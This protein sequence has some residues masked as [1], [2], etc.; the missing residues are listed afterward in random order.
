MSA[1]TINLE[2]KTQFLMKLLIGT[3]QEIERKIPL[4][5]T[6]GSLAHHN[7]LLQRP[8]KKHFSYV[9]KC[10]TLYLTTFLEPFPYVL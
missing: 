1:L 5:F 10:Q 2:C 3:A 8:I 9:G 4:P 6:G 7:A